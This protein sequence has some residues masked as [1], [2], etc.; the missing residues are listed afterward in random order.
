MTEK[1][2]YVPPAAA[3]PQTSCY[4]CIECGELV[5]EL[6]KT[7]SPGNFKLTHCD[8]CQ[9]I[10]DSLL[11]SEPL[12]IAL[13]LFLLKKRAY[14]HL[15][16]NRF[17]L[18]FTGWQGL[19]RYLGIVILFDAYIKWTHS[20]G[21]AESI[22]QSLITAESP[23]SF[24]DILFA[25]LLE[26]IGYVTGIYVGLLVA[27]RYFPLNARPTPHGQAGNAHPPRFRKTNVLVSVLVASFGK[28]LFL[29]ALVWDYP[30][31]FVDLINCFVFA[32]HVR[33]IEV[34]FFR[35]VRSVI[36]PAAVVACGVLV[37]FAV[38]CFCC[39][40][41][42]IPCVIKI[43][44]GETA[45]CRRSTMPDR[46][47]TLQPDLPA[48]NLWPFV[49][50]ASK[51]PH[52]RNETARTSSQRREP[53]RSAALAQLSASS[54]KVGVQVLSAVPW[55]ISPHRA[56]PSQMRTE[57]C[58][59]SWFRIYPGHGIRFVRLDSKAFL[60]ASG[61]CRHQFHMKRSPRTILWTGEWRK[62]HKKD[63]TVEVHKRAKRRTVRYQKDIIGMTLDEIRKTR[64]T[65]PEK[66]AAADAALKEVKAR[67][68]KQK[69]TTKF[70]GPKEKIAQ[71]TVASQGRK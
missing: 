7:F 12:P 61:K 42:A 49:K 35:T 53:P 56:Q 39:L 15:V 37:R 58:T 29:V 11:E 20:V 27:A 60:F 45:P 69:K 31:R 24:T 32:C 41:P 3:A 21:G 22:L 6:V 25:V 2:S 9:R 8:H 47:M 63:V 13:Q 57:R 28:A 46:D 23:Y 67:Q 1:L 26:Y 50:G 54:A 43:S 55:F 68:K 4:Q 70:D 62:A 19:V 5:G 10:A 17:L 30:L 59:Y 40:S 65:K 64:T 36:P 14:R 48:S 16:N 38:R 66:T 52:T 34:V 51:Q 18:T 71:K 44:R 33:S